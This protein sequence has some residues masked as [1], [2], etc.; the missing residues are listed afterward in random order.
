MLGSVFVHCRLRPMTFDEVDFTLA[1]LGGTF[2][3]ST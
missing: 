1:V 2:G 3:A